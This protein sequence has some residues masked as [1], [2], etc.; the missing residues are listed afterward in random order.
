MLTFATK[1]I[2]KLTK[3]RGCIKINPPAGPGE[4]MKLFACQNASDER[5]DV[6]NADKQ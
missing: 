6:A 4:A 3:Q 2:E 1:K 5:N